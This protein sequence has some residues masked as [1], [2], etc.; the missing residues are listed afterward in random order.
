MGEA[1]LTNS[2]ALFASA[3][4]YH[5]AGRLYDAERLYREV[6]AA[7]P[8]HA[9]CLALFGVLARQTARPDLAAFCL[10][11]AIGLKPQ[12]AN[13]HC[14][15]GSVLLAQGQ[16]A[17]AV[18]AFAAALAIEPGLLEA[19]NNQGNAL[20]AMGRM[21]EAA[22]CYRRA[23]ALQPKLAEAHYNL[24]STLAALGR[25]DDAIRSYRAALH[26]RLEY[27][28]AH[29]NLGLAFARQG[30]ADLAARSYA[31]ALACRPDFADAASNLAA[32]LPALSASQAAEACNDLG[33]A[34]LNQQRLDEGVAWLTRAVEL[35]PKLVEALNNLGVALRDQARPDEAVACLR[36]ALAARPGYA[37]AWN[38]LGIALR[39]IGQTDEGFDC[40]CHA[41]RLRPDL[42]PAHT[43]LSVALL[44]Q[45]RLPEAEASLR[46]ALRLAPNDAQVHYNLAQ[47]LLAQGRLEEGWQEAEWRW[48]ARQLASAYRGFAQPQWR[49]EP[50]QGR[51]LL[52]HAEQGFGDTLQ[53]CRYATLAAARGL[54]VVMEVQPPLVRLT[55]GVAG[56]AEVVAR[57]EALPA[58]DL[59]C[60]MMSMPLAFGTTLDSIPSAPAYL[61][62]DGAAVA[63]WRARL[64]AMPGRG[65]RVGLVWAGNP[66]SQAHEL[67]AIDRRRSLEAQ[68]LRPLFEVPEV[69]FFSLQKFGPDAA[70]DLPLIR[71]MHE[72]DDFADTA[73]LVANLD[74]V[75]SVDTAVAHLAAGLG[76]PVWVLDRF[77]ACWRW[78]D[79]RRDSPWYPSLRLYRQPRAGDWEAVIAEV[80]AD[81]RRLARQPELAGAAVGL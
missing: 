58:F 76:V 55:R 10:R 45:R 80:G 74:L 3:T 27:P 62:A 29:N 66:R 40:I 44:E 7:D 53:F 6:L 43:T 75:I 77:D 34:C 14:A 47:V 68:R 32:I 35:H 33:V 48:Q 56:V 16:H 65:L 37:D 2:Q 30:R 31:A 64:P 71:L 49:G 78:L 38:N 1:D 54:R 25:V 67:A 4:A 11:H 23:V 70:E 21:A 60:P 15:L 41:L 59:Q 46:K 13:F 52:L 28:E 72:M 69:Q 8:S 24:G 61:S 26:C 79:G 18:A 39:D 12:V 20:Q 19:L 51:T 42:R 63:A 5:G 57:G 81:L 17:E 9:E 36:R 73:A 22:E 50:A